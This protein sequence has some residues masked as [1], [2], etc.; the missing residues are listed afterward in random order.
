MT[1]IR[2]EFQEIIDIVPGA[3]ELYHSLNAAYHGALT[4]VHRQYDDKFEHLL[5]RLKKE[6]A[7]AV[8]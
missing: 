5:E 7:N 6:N 8:Q 4:S 1:I 2:E 3:R